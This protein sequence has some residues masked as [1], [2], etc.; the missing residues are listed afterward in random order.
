MQMTGSTR[1]IQ[2]LHGYVVRTPL[3]PSDADDP[4]DTVPE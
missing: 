2:V 1:Q 3:Q 4:A